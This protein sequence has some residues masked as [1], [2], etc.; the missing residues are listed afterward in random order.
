MNNSTIAQTALLA[1]AL[2]ATI[3][4]VAADEQ[5]ALKFSGDVTLTSDLAIR[6]MSYTNEEP[7]LHGS[8]KVEH[9]TGVYVRTWATNVNL[10]E[11]DTVKPEDRANLL[12]GLYLGYQGNFS[13]ISYDIQAVRYLFP[14]ADK[15]LNY[16]LTEY[17]L[18]LDYSLQGID[19]GVLYTYSPDFFLKSGKAHYYEFSASHTFAN[20]LGIGGIVGRQT[21]SDNETVGFDDY[22]YYGMWLTYPIGKFDVSLYYNNTDLD[23]ADDIN[24]D[25]RVYF[26]LAASF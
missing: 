7:A 4:Q 13:D 12:V 26:T 22:N 16:D 24:A 6:G 5:Q 19:L 18:D 17:T 8:F 20:D 14:G 10:L 1:T 21:V 15:D 3:P 9:Q 2:V 23:N 25:E 11:G